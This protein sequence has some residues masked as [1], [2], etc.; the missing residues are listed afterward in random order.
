MRS[1]DLESDAPGV[2]ACNMARLP[3]KDASV[4]VAVFSL[5]LMGTDYG[6]F[7]EEAHR[8]RLF[9]GVRPFALAFVFAA[10]SDRPD[11]AARGACSVFSRPSSL[12]D[13]R[14]FVQTRE[15]KRTDASLSPAGEPS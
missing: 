9:R 14:A 12:R 3:L 11:P 13:G 8:V 2:V 10:F 15:M 7:L 1:F 4:D 6:S 5:S